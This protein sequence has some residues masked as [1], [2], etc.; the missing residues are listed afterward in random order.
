MWPK[1]DSSGVDPALGHSAKTLVVGPGTQFDFSSIGQALEQAQ[2]GDTIEVSPGEYAESVVLKEG[3]NL[4][5][6]GS[7]EAVIL[8][9]AQAVEPSIA[10]VAHDLKRG[11]LAGFKIQGSGT[12]ALAIGLRLAD[13]SLEIEDLEISSTRIA[14][15]EIKGSSATLRANYIHDNLGSAVVISGMASPLLA[16]NVIVNNGKQ[17][18]NLKAGLEVLEGGRPAL[19]GNVIA[20][21]GIFGI[22]GWNADSGTL[23]RNFFRVD[24]GDKVRTTQRAGDAA[25]AQATDRRSSEQTPGGTR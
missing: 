7:G 6:Q 17:T 12:T 2:T 5:S 14:A 22:H 4:V 20:D 3:V 23:R 13:S 11:R 25:S 16:H 15:V 18:G 10:V 8:G 9:A 24:S 1:R 21:N 19:V